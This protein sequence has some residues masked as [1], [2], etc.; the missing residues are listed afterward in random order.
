MIV[1]FWQRRAA[2]PVL[3]RECL[4]I[5]E[6]RITGR[7]PFLEM[8]VGSHYFANADPLGSFEREGPTQLR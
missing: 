5:P 8:L 3:G 1:V 7:S 4:A 6:Q 2:R